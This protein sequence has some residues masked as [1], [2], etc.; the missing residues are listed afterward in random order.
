ML[1][2]LAG[3]AGLPPA[4]AHAYLVSYR[5]AG[6][7]EQDAASGMYSLGPF[8]LRLG[9]A[10]IQCVEPLATASRAAI[11][12]SRDLG[13]MVALIVWGPKAPTAVQVQE[14]AHTLNL[15]VHEGTVFS[16]IG[17]A[18]GRIFGAFSAAEAVSRRVRQELRGDVA[19]IGIGVRTP[20]G[21]FEAELKRIRRHG[22]STISGMPVPGINSAAAPVL[23]GGALA[24]AMSLIGPI[25]SLDLAPTSSAIAELKKTC[26]ELSRAASAPSF[27]V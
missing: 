12:L 27:E 16:V 14:G 17:S 9:L 22:H 4:Q 10:R 13:L 7:V 2:D 26:A 6:L 3:E 25:D 8:A 19:D 18:G 20:R 23:Q 11:R 21:E 15:N 1:R 5:R 24:L